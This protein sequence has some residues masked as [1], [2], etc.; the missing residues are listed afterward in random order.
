MK[1]T[2]ISF[3]SALLPVF[4]WGRNY[5]RKDLQSDMS[6][7]LVVL[8][9]TVPQVIAYAFLAGMPAEAGLYAAVAALLGYAFF[10][11]SRVLAVGPTAILAIMTLEVVSSHAVPGTAEYNLVAGQLC[12]ITGGVLIVLR[13][14]NFGAI[15]SFLSHAVVTG[16]ITAAA[17]LVISNQIPSIIGLTA[18]R[19]TSILGILL[20]LRTAF[21]GFNPA[22]CGISVVAIGLL[23]L[24]RMRLV[25]RWLGRLGLRD[26]LADALVKSAPM[27]VV[28]AGIILVQ[29]LALDV[30]A[31]VP[32]VGAIPTRLPDINLTLVDLDRVQTLLPS[33]VLIAM[34]V[35]MESISIGTAMA[36]K[37]RQ[38]VEPNQELAGLGV[39]NLGASLVGGF[40]V[41]GSFARTAINF[42]SGAVSPMAS[43]MTALLVMATLLLFAST[44][45]Y[46][47]RAVLS[48][49]IVVSAWQ[50][51]DWPAIA[52][53]FVFNR[54]DAVTFVFTFLAV[55]FFGVEAGVLAGV[56]ISF[57]LL[58]RSASRPHIAVVG[59]VGDS[60][61]FRNIER[62]KVKTSPAVLAIRVDESM[63]FVNTRF[64]ET[65]VLDRV[66]EAPTVEH[67]LLICTATNFIDTSGLVMLEELSGNLLEADITLHLA[68]VKGPVMD[69]LRDTGFYQNMKGKVFF[70]TD[71]AIRELAGI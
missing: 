3:S 50:L 26:A 56:V 70:T 44:F 52:R 18:S 9:I 15:I 27:C 4:V 48:A 57:V 55:I 24:C 42:S 43:V 22:V 71:I 35:F 47:P 14:L 53:I 68:E 60:E 34:V 20:H 21:A 54:V 31:S 41:A 11:S 10:G 19:D 23:L 32:V 13:C 36:S 63:Y 65:F 39:A 7:G 46:L 17:L 69:K 59:R 38:R 28:V 8:F 2:L 40:P 12:V 16:F 51:V 58:I 30:T 45:Y 6:A 1:K 66:A 25:R 64:I 67:V 49:I 29:M 62:H 37:R 61:H 5:G 33:A